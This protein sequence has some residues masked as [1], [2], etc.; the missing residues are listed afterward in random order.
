MKINQ[1]LIL[2]TKRENFEH[3][4][5]IRDKYETKLKEETGRDLEL[6]KLA[7][8]EDLKN[9]EATEFYLWC[10]SDLSVFQDKPVP[11]NR[12]NLLGDLKSFS[13]DKIICSNTDGSF[14]KETF[15]I[16]RDLVDK[17]FDE[18][19]NELRSCGNSCDDKSVLSS[20]M[21]K[22]SNMFQV[23]DTNVIVYI[24]NKL[25]A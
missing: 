23:L 2:F 8:D 19:N 12:L 4:N 17:I 16:H 14:S 10:D 21:S 20:L 7:K 1:R 5:S 9:N 24:Y 6:L 25:N 11:K 13:K 18:Y 3:I 22:K 15:L